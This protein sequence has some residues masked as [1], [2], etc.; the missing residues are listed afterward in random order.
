[1]AGIM[2]LA[3]LAFFLLW[4]VG[5]RGPWVWLP[6]VI[7]M[8]GVGSFQAIYGQSVPCQMSGTAN[9]LE[10]PDLSVEG[11]AC[12]QPFRQRRYQQLVMQDS[13]ADW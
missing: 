11:R 2:V 7:A 5:N 6:I 3:L 1:M 9:H 12:S 8:F 13:V 4:A 10:S